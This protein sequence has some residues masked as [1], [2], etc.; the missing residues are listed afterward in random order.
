ML[1]LK[2]VEYSVGEFKLKADFKI[3]RLSKVALIGPS[4]AGK[5]TLLSL[6]SGFLKPNSGSI[7]IDNEDIIFSDKDVNLVSIASYDNFHFKQ[8]IKGLTVGVVKG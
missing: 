5:S 2:S 4:G 3:P 6:I 7:I 1:S 8:I